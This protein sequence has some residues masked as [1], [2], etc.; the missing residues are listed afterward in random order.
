M[1]PRTKA[2]FGRRAAHVSPVNGDFR[3]GGV[4]LKLHFTFSEKFSQPPCAGAGAGRRAEPRILRRRRSVRDW[5]SWSLPAFFSVSRGLAELQLRPQSP[6][7][8]AF[9]P[10]STSL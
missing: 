1:R 2:D 3:T 4:E 6:A 10:V 5:R 7:E 9:P 8:P